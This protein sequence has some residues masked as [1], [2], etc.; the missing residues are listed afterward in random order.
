LLQGR[1]NQ[2]RKVI[3]ADK[4]TAERKKKKKDPKELKTLNF[5]KKKAE[6]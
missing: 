4:K 6:M 1:T 5:D 3:A 2:K